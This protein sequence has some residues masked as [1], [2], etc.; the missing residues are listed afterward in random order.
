MKNE[1]TEFKK[2][3][4]ELMTGELDLEQYP[5]EESAVVKDEFLKGMPC[6]KAYRQMYE[7]KCHLYR[8]MGV[9][10]EED[11]EIII[12]S[13]LKITEHLSYKMYDYG[14]LFSK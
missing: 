13:L 12:N 1:S 2:K 6:E 4:Y 7:A 11:I 9:T 10:E 3:I 5:V 14:A 8:K